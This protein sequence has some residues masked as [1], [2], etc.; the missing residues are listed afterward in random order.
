MKYIWILDGNFLAYEFR[1]CWLHP[2]NN[3][4]NNT[5]GNGLTLVVS[6]NIEILGGVFADCKE[7]TQA[8]GIEVKSDCSYVTVKDSVVIGNVG[9]GILNSA[10][11]AIKIKD[12]TGYTTDNTGTATILNGQSS[13]AVTHR[14]VV[15]PTKITVTGST[16]D[17][18]ALYVD[19]IGTTTFTV[20]SSGNVG[21]NR[22]IYWRAEI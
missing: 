14:L 8:Y 11:T 15:A 1:I 21:G 4:Q 13:I 19:T 20:H 16:S 2:N 9:G 12:N 22:T 3:K 10:S 5:S 17:T 18:N 6:D 7:P